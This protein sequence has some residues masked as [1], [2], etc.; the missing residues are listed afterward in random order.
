MAPYAHLL[1]L[2]ILFSFIL[3]GTHCMHLKLISYAYQTIFL[4]YFSGTHC[5]HL[6]PTIFF[7]SFRHTLHCSFLPP[8]PPPHLL[9]VGALPVKLRVPDL[10][11]GA[12]RAAVL[13]GHPGDADEVLPAVLRVRVLGEDAHGHVVRAR[14]GVA[15]LQLALL[16][17]ALLLATVD[18]R[19]GWRCTTT[20]C[21]AVCIRR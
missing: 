21:G 1:C 14:E 18:L 10:K 20:T 8:P 17:H 7:H 12:E 19:E 16:V 2:T 3:S 5:M 6:T 13:P 11:D 15:A 4:S 9:R